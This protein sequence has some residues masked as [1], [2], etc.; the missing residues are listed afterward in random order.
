M[1]VKAVNDSVLANEVDPLV[2][3]DDIAAALSNS[4]RRV[5]SV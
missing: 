1:S 3:P 2:G 4:I 5:A